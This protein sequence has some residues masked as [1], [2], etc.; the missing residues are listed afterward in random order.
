[1]MIY[2]G[3][4]LAVLFLVASFWPKKPELSDEEHEEASGVI[5]ADQGG[6]PLPPLDLVVPPTPRSLQRAV[7]SPAQQGEE[8]TSG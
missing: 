4:G 7:A 1:M 5:P 6:F 2:V 8:E 3:I